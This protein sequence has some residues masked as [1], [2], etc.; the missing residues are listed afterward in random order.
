MRESN[1]Y[2]LTTT[3]CTTGNETGDRQAQL[4]PFRQLD[5]FS[6]FWDIQI[7]NEN[8]DASVVSH[9]IWTE[10]RVGYKS[11]GWD[12]WDD[13]LSL[14]LLKQAALGRRW[15]TSSPREGR[16]KA[17]NSSNINL[18]S[19]SSMYPVY[20]AHPL[21]IHQHVALQAPHTRLPPPHRRPI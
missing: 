7:E 17:S 12:G 14:S 5:R 1:S 8:K 20:P 19:S 9:G 6:E 15:E 10:G 3:I 21:P 11:G 2:L 16:S 18:S 4:I 13:S